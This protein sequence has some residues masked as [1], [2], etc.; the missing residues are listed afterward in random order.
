MADV[1][2]DAQLGPGARAAQQEAV[3]SGH[4]NLLPESQIAPMTRIQ[5]ARDRA[6]AQ[7][8]LKARV[9]GKTVL[10]VSGAGH[11]DKTVGVPQQLPIE[12]SVKVLRLEAGDGKADPAAFD[13]VWRTPALPEKDYCAELRSR[14]KA[15]G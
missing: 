7:T 6:M 1:S 10:L 13:A 2:L 15:A 9:A 12:L 14:S 11:G 3:R 8:I 4:C 5:I